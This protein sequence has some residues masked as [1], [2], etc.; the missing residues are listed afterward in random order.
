MKRLVAEVNSSC[1]V[2]VPNS[3]VQIKDLVLTLATV[4]CTM[5][6]AHLWQEL[7]HIWVTHPWVHG[8]G[9]G[10][11]KLPS[12]ALPCLFLSCPSLTCHALPRFVLP[13]PDL[14]YL[15]L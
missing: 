3:T 7:E 14:S 15:A 10:E 11:I 12:S 5:N 1:L 9:K 6:T 4:Q 2:F 13:S 8:L